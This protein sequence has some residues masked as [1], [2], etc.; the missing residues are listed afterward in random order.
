MQANT[1][2]VKQLHNCTISYQK[3]APLHTSLVVHIVFVFANYELPSQLVAAL[4][5]LPALSC[6]TRWQWVARALSYQTDADN[7]LSVK[8]APTHGPQSPE[9][10]SAME[11]TASLPM[12]QRM[13][14]SS[15][16]RHSKHAKSTHGFVRTGA[17]SPTQQLPLLPGHL[18]CRC[19]SAL[20]SALPDQPCPACPN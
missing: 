20:P 9:P 18:C 6:N 17:D 3:H 14:H 8:Q 16:R 15:R 13:T 10:S 5:P 11:N 7:T 12:Q 2:E 1:A 19:S 4:L